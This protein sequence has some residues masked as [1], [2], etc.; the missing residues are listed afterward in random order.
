MSFSFSAL[1]L[2]TNL[3]SLSC[4]KWRQID[5]QSRFSKIGTT[6]ISCT[7]SFVWIALQY[8]RNMGK[9]FLYQGKAALIF[10]LYLT[11][12]K[13][14]QFLSSDYFKDN[15][16]KCLHIH[17]LRWSDNKGSTM[18][19]GKKP[20]ESTQTEKLARDGNINSV[21]LEQ[22]ISELSDSIGKQ[23]MAR[24]WPCLTFNMNST[25][26]FL[27]LTKGKCTP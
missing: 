24:Y 17:T 23:A 25:C 22:S 20:N 19:Q 14:A 1:Y 16:Q 8:F 15:H 26:C 12:E 10:H 18:I 7:E 27:M 4:L 6:K 5:K 13:H 2:F 21:D 11:F 3:S 9:S